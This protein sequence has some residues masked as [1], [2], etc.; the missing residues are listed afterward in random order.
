MT[1]NIMRYIMLILLVIGFYRIGYSAD[2]MGVGEAE[3][4]VEKHQSAEN[5]VEIVFGRMADNEGRY[6][7]K[8]AAEKRQ[9]IEYGLRFSVEIENKLSEPLRLRITEKTPPFT[10]DIYDPLNNLSFGPYFKENWVEWGEK[11]GDNRRIFIDG[12]SKMQLGSIVFKNYTNED[13]LEKNITP[14]R[15][16]IKVFFDEYDDSKGESHVR[17]LS[18]K[19]EN[20]EVIME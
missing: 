14:G 8:I 2:N 7:V 19:V 16:V 20:A 1:N 18:V 11:W 17:Y 10:F 12:N 4:I 13:G 15:Y 6:E 5:K 3:I 9:S